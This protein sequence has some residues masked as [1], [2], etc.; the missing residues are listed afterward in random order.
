MMTDPEAQPELTTDFLRGWPLPQP[1][2]ED[3]KH[4]RGQVLVVGG[5]VAIPGATM[6]SGLAA[7]RAG[8]GKVRVATTQTTAVALG[9]AM[10]EAMVAGFPEVGEGAIDPAA[11][12]RIVE[13]AD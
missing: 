7:L 5:S 8:A 10:P 2:D 9:V 13:L 11:A 1:D 3:D 4:D 6:L 12:H